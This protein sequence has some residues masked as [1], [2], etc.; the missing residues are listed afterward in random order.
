MAFRIQNNHET[1][2]ACALPRQT[3]ITIQGIISSCFS[4]TF[5]SLRKWVTP[6]TCLIGR[7]KA[8]HCVP[9]SNFTNGVVFVAL[10]VRNNLPVR[11]KFR[12]LFVRSPCFHGW[13]LN[14][15]GSLPL[16]T[17]TI[18]TVRQQGSPIG[19]CVRDTWTTPLDLV[20][21]MHQYGALPLEIQD[22]LF[23]FLPARRRF[24]LERCSSRF[25]TARLLCF[26]VEDATERCS[27]RFERACF[28]LCLQNHQ[29]RRCSL[30]LRAHHE[31]YLK[32]N[33]LCL[34]LLSV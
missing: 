26:Q 5:M 23:S 25:Q 4:P 9:P 17:T 20:Q 31:L 8:I 13:H 24:F 19:Q 21:N 29:G 34:L 10:L 32:Y 16:P 12:F 1:G 7:P 14:G 18:T 30:H 3:C 11:S 2:R 27:S 33:R 6:R 22:A 28:Q 15:V